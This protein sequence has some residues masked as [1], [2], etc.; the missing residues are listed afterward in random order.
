MD[1]KL[2]CY[3][4]LASS[5]PL[6][7]SWRLNYPRKERYR[8]FWAPCLAL[9]ATPG[10]IL[11]FHYHFDSLREFFERTFGQAG[12]GIS[13]TDFPLYLN[14]VLLTAFMLIK[15][16]VNGSMRMG[17]TGHRAGQENHASTA[18]N[19]PPGYESVADKGIFL[20]P[21][22]FFSGS[23]FLG[24]AAAAFVFYLASVL[25]W[26]NAPFSWPL[27]PA[28]SVVVLCEVA[29]YLR[30]VRPDATL[31]SADA[32]LVSTA[33]FSDLW[34]KYQELWRERVLVAGRRNNPRRAPDRGGPAEIG[35]LLKNGEN[36]LLSGND[37]TPIFP[38][39]AEHLWEVLV[40][41]GKILVLGDPGAGNRDPFEQIKAFL[42]ERLDPVG[43]M[44]DVWRMVG[45]EEFLGS[46]QLPDVLLAGPAQLVR[47]PHLRFEGDWFRQLR[48][49]LV[50]ESSPHWRQLPEIRAVMG[51]L[52][53]GQGKTP[54]FLILAEPREFSQTARWANFGVPLAER[55]LEQTL[56]G[57]MQYVVWKHE[58][59]RQFQHDLIKR[60]WSFD[61]GPEAGLSTL[62][63]GCQLTPVLNLFQENLPWRQRVEELQKMVNRGYVP[64]EILCRELRRQSGADLPLTDARV[65]EFPRPSWVSAG[66]SRACVM[67]RDSFANPS[68]TLNR[69]LAKGFD[70]AFVHVVSPP[71]LLRDYLADNIEFF[72]EHP[73][74]PLTPRIS[75]HPYTVALELLNRLLSGAV[76]GKKALSLLRLAGRPAGNI[77]DG[78][79]ALFREYFGVDILT[80]NLLIDKEKRTWSLVPEKNE[81]LEQAPHFTLAPN[82]AAVLSGA[83]KRFENFQ[84][85]DKRTGDIL[86]EI[87]ADH[88]YQLYLPMQIHAF[89]GEPYRVESID[90]ESKKVNLR[91]L[92][93]GS[94]DAIYRSS[95]VIDLE[96]RRP[97][98]SRMRK[99]LGGWQV[100][101]HLLEASFSV[102]TVG[103]FRFEGKVAPVAQEDFV[104]LGDLVPRR[105]YPH[106]R[107]LA[108]SFARE[109]DRQ[110]GKRVAFTLAALLNEVF[111]SLFPETRSFVH[112]GTAIDQRENFFGSSSG[113]EK[114]FPIFHWNRE[115]SKD[116]PGCEFELLIVEDAHGDMGLVQCLYDE[117]QRV[118]E[119]LYDYLAWV[120]KGGKKP[121]NETWRKKAIR[122]D[123]YLCY[124]DRQISKV[125]DPAGARAFL[126]SL[127]F[128]HDGDSLFAQ[129]K[130]FYGGEKDFSGFRLN[131]DV[132]RTTIS[133]D[134][135]SIHAGDRG[136]AIHQ[137]DFCGKSLPARELELIDGLLER[138]PEC[139]ENAVSEFSRMV[140][141]YQ[142]AKTFLERDLGL[143]LRGNVGVRFASTT[144]I[145]QDSGIEFIAT[146]RCDPR[147]TGLAVAE[148]NKRMIL[149][150]N[151]SP[152]GTILGTTVHELTHV[153]QQD[154]LDCTRMQ[155]EHGLLLIEGLAQWAQLEC[156]GKRGLLPELC[157]REKQRSDEYG[158][159]YRMVV[160]MF[161][162]SSG[163]R[164]PFDVLLRKYR[165]RSR[166]K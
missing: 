89:H 51:L 161:E 62:A 35:N 29:W 147:A 94:R 17:R 164:S 18:S 128:C 116:G 146:S 48:L 71:C 43:G 135:M 73:L 80:G 136:N 110:L 28:L 142:E 165:S 97:P 77:R 74:L 151:G 34:E 152:Y 46:P 65:L 159:G 134:G 91:F 14:W 57:Q 22:W 5:I 120:D 118:F 85:Q 83:L 42:K 23:C 10:V 4:I 158:Q 32:V 106:G 140:E 75:M 38:Q 144:R 79:R 141:I 84:M 138:C 41:G 133:S 20:E 60:E 21:S 109:D 6:L 8:Q 63:V 54:Q 114:M 117:W 112:A 31:V 96:N 55:T 122:S 36:V 13:P 139:A 99:N 95:L 12:T 166:R 145:Q 15:L 154:N 127:G 24:F 67:A 162:A 76:A 102:E 163:C 100:D 137:C 40:D 47:N 2:A 86:A 124:G 59:S 66:R 7:I 132:V 119:I 87:S 157:A 153:W 92:E 88:L 58:G 3:R 104:A 11:V 143:A 90:R 61:V 44:A 53:D 26:E 33:G 101:C 72:E 156:L 125:L 155:K 150:E 1:F 64:E 50:T 78:L 19:V 126:E 115:N 131:P 68:F 148:G 45:L 113:L 30:G 121:L 130:A 52:E 39:L 82:A 37:W 69:S 49:V 81:F 160:K 111:E 108:I 70:S 93:K 149:I 98:F 103:Y 16:L 105:H 25:F 123:A 129:R 56:P 9:I 27:L 107:M